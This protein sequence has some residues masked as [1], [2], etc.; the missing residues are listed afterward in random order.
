VP[1]DKL[2]IDITS[3]VNYFV[4]EEIMY[5]MGFGS[6]DFYFYKPLG[7]KI[8]A[9]PLWD[10]DQMLMADIGTGFTRPPTCDNNMYRYLLKYPE[11]RTL[12]QERLMWVI[13]NLS[14]V[15]SQHLDMLQNNPTLRAAVER[16]EAKHRTWGNLID[17][18]V[19]YQNPQIVS[20]TS[21]DQ[22]VEHI[23]KLLFT[24]YEV[25][26]KTASRAEWILSHF[27]ELK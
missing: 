12:M 21:W 24:G 2:G 27:E 16:N 26:G 23:R 3:F 17:I 25:N 9:G 5:D 7:G 10:F 13:E 20:Y 15:I 6:S 11:F 22:H 1:L 19:F 4:F 18:G 14:P 8:T